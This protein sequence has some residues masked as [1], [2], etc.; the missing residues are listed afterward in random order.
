MHR[1]AFALASMAI[2]RISHQG[3][4]LCVLLWQWV[5]DAVVLWQWVRAAVVLWQWVLDAVVRVFA[6]RVRTLS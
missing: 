6:F 4:S 3:R 5:L 1:V 2:C